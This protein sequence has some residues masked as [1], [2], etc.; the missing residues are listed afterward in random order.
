M[1]FSTS[2]TD[3]SLACRS[4]SFTRSACIEIASPNRAFQH[5]LRESGSE[6]LLEPAPL[7]DQRVEVG[8]GERRGLLP[9]LPGQYVELPH[10]RTSLQRPAGVHVGPVR[11]GGTVLGLD[12]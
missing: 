1:R 11:I 12:A 10:Q 6:L 3:P 7:L 5:L 4:S 2:S 8:S 9:D